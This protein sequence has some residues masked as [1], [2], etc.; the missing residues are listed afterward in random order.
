MSYPHFK[1]LLA[2][3]GLTVG[4]LLAKAGVGRAHGLQVL[5]GARAGGET[6]DRLV[7]FL[8]EAEVAALGWRSSRG[9]VAVERTGG[10]YDF[11]A[12]LEYRALPGVDA[13]VREFL[14]GMNRLH[15]VNQSDSYATERSK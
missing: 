14:E 6:R 9:V 4:E 13:L 8:T 2:G 5:S 12:R 1:K 3:R 11:S 7:P 10:I 15:A